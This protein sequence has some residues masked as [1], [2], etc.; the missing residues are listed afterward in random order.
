MDAP[1]S[2]SVVLSDEGLTLT[3]LRSTLKI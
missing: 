2:G 1:C 3:A